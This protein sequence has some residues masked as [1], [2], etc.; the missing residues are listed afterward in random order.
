MKSLACTGLSRSALNEN[1]SFHSSGQADSAGQ[2]YKPTFSL[3]TTKS[4][5]YTTIT[6]SDNRNGIPSVGLDTVF[7]PF[8]TTTGQQD[9]ELD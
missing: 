1:A 3:T 4:I 7:Q 2:D 6:V 8:F 5:N 9:R